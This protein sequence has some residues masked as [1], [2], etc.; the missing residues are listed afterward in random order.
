MPDQ[1]TCVVDGLRK[2]SLKDLGLETTLQEIFNLKR[3][4][5]IETHAR[6]VQDTNANKTT[7]EGVAFE[8]TLGVFGIEL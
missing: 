6:F 3:Q 7:N 8:E 4:H 5:V 2:A 1:Y